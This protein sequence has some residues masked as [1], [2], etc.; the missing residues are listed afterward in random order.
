MSVIGLAFYF[1]LGGNVLFQWGL[2]PSRRGIRSASLPSVMAFMVAASV[3][4]TVAG[5]VFRY[6]LTPWG[7]ESFAPVVLILLLL[8][9]GLAAR[10]IGAVTGKANPLRID[11]GTLQSTLVLYAIAIMAGGNFSSIWL[12]L[13]GGA[14][15]ALGYL[16]ATRFLDDIMD[17]L[18][19]E[20][21]PAPFRGT[22]IRF[23][24]TGL[25]ALA[26]AGIDASFFVK[27]SG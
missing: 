12:M 22:P 26:F 21:V 23:I 7:L 10:A 14:S 4:G 9:A 6:V 5:L 24:S 8:G 2:I 16:A 13:G 3:G 18:D 19:L 1:A 25:M 11:D 20:P 17:R 27:F 15:A